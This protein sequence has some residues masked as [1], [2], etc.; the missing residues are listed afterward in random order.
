[1]RGVVAGLVVVALAAVCVVVFMGRGEKPVEKVEKGRGRIKEVAPAAAPKVAMS[2]VDG[3]NTKT[4][5]RPSGAKVAAPKDRRQL[6]GSAARLEEAR[7]MGIKPIFR[8][9]SE[10]FLAMFAIP[11]EVVPPVPV[12]KGLE[13][14]FANALLDPIVI[15]DGDSDE[16]IQLKEMVAGMKDEAKAYIKA[17]GTLEG[18]YE[19]LFKRQKAEAD[20]RADANALVAKS[21]ADDGDPE[22]TYKIWKK[23][24]EQLDSKGIKRLPLHPRLM[25]R[26]D[27]E[28]ASAQQTMN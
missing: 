18:F 12:H 10:S 19:E 24:N 21:M 14:D 22:L 15:E 11:G 17:G 27:G 16:V 20:F 6:R 25:K 8:H 2:E 7:R 9:Q 4:S 23:M 26:R 3:V 5:A 13:Q 28:E 1:M